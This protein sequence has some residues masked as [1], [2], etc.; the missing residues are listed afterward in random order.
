MKALWGR[1]A[2]ITTDMAMALS[3][4]GVAGDSCSIPIMQSQMLRSKHGTF[5]TAACC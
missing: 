3:E 1:A 5:A 4:G 2:C